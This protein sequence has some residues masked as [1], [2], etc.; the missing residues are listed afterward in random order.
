MLKVLMGGEAAMDCSGF[1][2]LVMLKALWTL[3]SGFGLAVFLLFVFIGAFITDHWQE[4]LL[5]LPFL[6]FLLL[7]IVVFIFVTTL[8]QDNA[9]KDSTGDLCIWLHWGIV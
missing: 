7:G 3:F 9:L 1:A 4:L 6:G 8:A 5:V 2:L